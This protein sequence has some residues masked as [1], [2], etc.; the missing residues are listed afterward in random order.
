MKWY[1]SYK[2]I[3]EF[4]GLSERQK[5]VVWR[6]CFLNGLNFRTFFTLAIGLCWLILSE[7]LFEDSR[8]FD[9]GILWILALSVRVLPAV[10]FFY[11]AVVVGIQQVRPY[12]R[13][14]LEEQTSEL[15]DSDV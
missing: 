12:V 4:E 6:K 14:Y 2:N 8:A 15:D 1:W 7:E 13:Q 9:Q 3:P 5:K 10:A 11:L